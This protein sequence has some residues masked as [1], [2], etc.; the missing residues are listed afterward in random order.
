MCNDTS[1]Q[2]KIECPI[3]LDIECLGDCENCNYHKFFKDQDN[4][5]SCQNKI[6]LCDEDVK[7]FTLDKIELLFKDYFVN[8]VCFKTPEGEPMKRVATFYLENK[9]DLPNYNLSHTKETDEE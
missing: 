7:N 6:Y 5:T 3:N 1:Y 4:D 2:S 9:I 8:M